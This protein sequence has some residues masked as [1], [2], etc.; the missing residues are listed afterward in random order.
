MRLST[1]IRWTCAALAAVAFTACVPS[2]RRFPLREPMWRDADTTPVW[3]KCHHERAAKEPR[4]VSC[5]PDVTFNPIIWD[6]ADNMIFRPMSEALGVVTSGESVDVN[7][8]DEVP[9]SSWFTNRIGVQPMSPDEMAIGACTPDQLLDGSTAP[10]G[11]WVIDKGK[12]DGSTDG[13]RI[14]IPGRGK[15][16]LKADDADTPEHASGA[17]SLGARVLHAAGYNT[18]CEQVVYFRPSVLKLT[19]G[20]RWKHNFGDETAFD[21]AQLEK[22]LAHCPKRDGL[23]RM[24]AS[25]WLPGYN[26]GGFRFFGTR[27]DDPNDVVPHENRRELRGRRLLDAWIDRFDERRGNTVDMWYAEKPGPPD[28]SP[29][30]VVHFS[31]DTS[32]TLGS[33]WNWDAVTRRLGY[34]YVLDWGEMGEDFLTLGTHLE[35]WDRTGRKPGMEFFA[36]FNVE[37]FVA[38]EWKNEYPVAS[39]SRMTERDGAWMARILARFTPEDVRALAESARFT[40]AE[41]TDYLDEVLEGR[42]R[43]ILER[44]LTRLSPVADVHVEDRNVLCGVDLAEWRGLRPRD[45]FRYAARR[46]D[47]GTW[48]H[49]ERRAGARVCVTLPEIG[50]DGG[51]ADDDPSRYVRVRIEDGVAKGPLVAHLYDLGP[52]RGYRLVGL[53]RPEK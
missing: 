49:V 29:G 30:H 28:G 46:L 25:A 53:E 33:S 10:D 19:P 9:D 8:L 31:M 24:A 21:Q 36:Y 40:K 35:P 50:R 43:K 41:H 7:S 6:G 48:L 32:E 52:A 47:G 26:V 27:S 44:Y 12:G 51:V 45:A 42:L 34:A 14:N 18:S 3:V 5:A 1:P 37:E 20:L 38:D 16:L 39:F 4:H 17:Q 22:V 23:V 15:Y 11:S 13:F 2:E